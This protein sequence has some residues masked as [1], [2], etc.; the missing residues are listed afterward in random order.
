MGAKE[1]KVGRPI[2]ATGMAYAPTNEQGVVYL[3][4]RLAPRLGFH[5]EVVQTAF[6]ASSYKVHPP[7]RC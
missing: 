7:L 5:V 6:W 3:F 1:P 4:G 2:K